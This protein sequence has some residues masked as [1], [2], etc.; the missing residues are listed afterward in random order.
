MEFDLPSTEDV[1]KYIEKVGETKGNA[2]L[3]QLRQQQR[4]IDAWDGPLGEQ[5]LRDDIRRH[6]E[7]LNKVLEQTATPAELAEVK[8]LWGRI[9]K[10]SNVV[11]AYQQTIGLVKGTK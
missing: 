6:E 2:T 10:I 9:K 8:Y 1:W 3:F 5:L 11:Y 7:L 4:F